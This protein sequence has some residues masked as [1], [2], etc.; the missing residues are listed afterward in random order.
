M[1][2]AAFL[3]TSFGV[4]LQLDIVYDHSTNYNSVLSLNG[5]LLTDKE[6]I[7]NKCTTILIAVL[8][9]WGQS[10]FAYDDG[11][12]GQRGGTSFGGHSDSDTGKGNHLSK[13]TD[14]TYEY[15]K[16]VY[17]GKLKGYPKTKYCVVDKESGEKVT[18]KRKT[19]K[20]Y[21]K[22]KY[23]VLL[24]DLY[25]CDNPEQPLYKTMKMKDVL[26]I[27]YYLDKRYRLRLL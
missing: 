13:T 5:C 12:P 20:D 26:A 4:K 11:P 14:Q 3:F 6:I 15:G 16:A 7:M 2:E 18:I 23:Q 22:E 8:L 21:R 10:V 19:L 25:S 9:L 17:T 24:Q 27:I 1:K